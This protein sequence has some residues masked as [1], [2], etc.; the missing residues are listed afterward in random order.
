MS[1]G[2]FTGGLHLPYK[3][4]VTIGSTNVEIRN[5]GLITAEH[6]E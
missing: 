1:I 3:V 6:T 4:D 2:W 5:V